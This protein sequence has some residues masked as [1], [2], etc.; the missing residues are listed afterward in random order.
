VVALHAA[1]G[2]MAWGF[3]LVHHDLWDYDTAPPPLLATLRRGTDQLPVVIQGN[4]TG[5]VYVLHRD[6]GEPASPIE[7]RAV[8]PSEV[9]GETASPTQPFPVSLPAL[10]PQR[11]SPDQVWGPTPADR[12]AC[13]TAIRQLR[14]DGV[15]TPPSVGGSLLYPGNTGGLTWSG[16]AFDP[17][18]GLLLVNTNNLPTRA[19]LL[20]REEFDNPQRQRED[21][22]YGRQAGA[23]YGMFRHF[24]VSPS[25]FPCSPPPWGQLVALDLNTESIR[26]QVPLGSMEVPRLFLQV[27][28]TSA[29]RSSPP[30]G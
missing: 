6:T 24:L 25:G 1:T 9:P 4:K 15:F 5:F 27:R 26:W 2:E 29:D 23:P 21:G 22:E 30:V 16:Y 12:E 14:N 11:L 13:R 10:T 19:R 7:E 28:S 20:P 18:R 3:Q 17:D 8:P